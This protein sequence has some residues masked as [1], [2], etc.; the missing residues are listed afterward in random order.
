MFDV[1][2]D[3]GFEVTSEFERGVGHVVLSLS[4]TER[5]EDLAAARSRAAATASMKAFFE[6]RVVAVV[7]ANRERGKIGSEILHNLLAAGFTGSIVPVHPTAAELE[8]LTAYRRVVDI[9]GPVDLAVIVVPAAQVLQAV[10][11]C[12][13][14]KVRAICVISAGFSECDARR[15]GSRSDSREPHSPSRMP[16]D[17]AELHGPPQH[18]SGGTV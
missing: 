1:F 16:T 3:S 10:D 6:P 15:P 4:L 5:F 13:A 11:D 17:W 9:P 14:K 8:G 2:R 18:G 7:G 12:I